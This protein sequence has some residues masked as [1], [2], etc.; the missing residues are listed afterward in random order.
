VIKVSDAGGA[1]YATPEEK[2]LTIAVLASLDSCVNTGDAFKFPSVTLPGSRITVPSFTYKVSGKTVLD[3]SV[4]FIEESLADSDLGQGVDATIAAVIGGYKAHCLYYYVFAPS[5]ALNL[6]PLGVGHPGRP[7]DKGRTDRGVEC[8][9]GSVDSLPG[10]GLGRPCTTLCPQQN[11]QEQGMN[12]LIA[13]YSPVS[14][15]FLRSRNAPG[16]MMPG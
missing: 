15:S 7:H 9:R 10:K 11:S 4:L 13:L 14:A 3:R 8:G 6:C 2:T 16:C 5:F 12:V 1:Q